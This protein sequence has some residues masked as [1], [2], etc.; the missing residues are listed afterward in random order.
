VE[1]EFEDPTLAKMDLTRNSTIMRLWDLTDTYNTLNKNAWRQ[2]INEA[3]GAHQ[4]SVV[5]LVHQG[6]D[7]RSNAERWTFPTALMFT[8][9]QLI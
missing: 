5:S 9:R 4:T 6:Y 3:L 1:T 7:G 2:Q 8:L